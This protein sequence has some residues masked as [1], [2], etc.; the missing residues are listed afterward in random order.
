MVMAAPPMKPTTAAWD[1]KSIKKPNLNKFFKEVLGQ[2][3]E[4]ESLNLGALLICDVGI[5]D[6]PQASEC[7][8]SD[9]GEERGG[10]G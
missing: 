5:S 1:K 9:T 10:K 2:E 8:L 7:C 6:L 3:E 4:E